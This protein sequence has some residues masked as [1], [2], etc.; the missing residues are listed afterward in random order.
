MAMEEAF[1][2]LLGCQLC[3]RKRDRAMLEG[4][5][6][7]EFLMR[8]VPVYAALGYLDRLKKLAEELS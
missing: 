3:T 8:G 7:A 4:K 5:A 6:V 1:A 2:S